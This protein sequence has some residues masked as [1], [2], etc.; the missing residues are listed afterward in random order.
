MVGSPLDRDGN[1]CHLALT[2]SAAARLGQRDQSAVRV[3]D[4]ANDAQTLLL[5]AFGQVHR[6]P[7]L[8]RPVGRGLRRD[9]LGQQIA[10]QLA[11]NGR[12]F[13]PTTQTVGILGY[14]KFSEK[15][16]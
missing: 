12:A 3:G 5:R 8:V 7:Q 11:W 14:S 2:P 6:P 1:R 4:P 9:G 10:H 16:F 15:N 13:A